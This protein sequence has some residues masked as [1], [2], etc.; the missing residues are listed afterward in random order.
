MEPLGLDDLP[1][2]GVGRGP[3]PTG[4]PVSASLPSSR[5]RADDGD[6]LD[7]GLVRDWAMFVLRAPGRH[8]ALA[9]ACFLAI[10]GGAATSLVVLPKR[11]QVRA[12]ILTQPNPLFI[13][14]A[15][16]GGL[17]QAAREI[18]LRRDNVVA[19]LKQTKF[20]ERHEAT[21]A[22]AAR[23]KAWL[24]D[25]IRGP[26]TREQRLEEAADAVEE[27]LAIGVGATGTLDLS[28]EWSNAELTFDVVQ[29]AIQS[30]IESRYA[31]E[32]SSI[33]E[34]IAILEE[35]ATRL[36]HDIGVRT[37]EVQSLEHELRPTR[38][39]AYVRRPTRRILHD[40][41]LPK[42]E[43]RLAE[44]R[45]AL[46]E[47]ED[48]RRRQVSDLQAQLVQQQTIYADRHPVL[49]AT[50]RNIAALSVQSPAVDSLRSEVA[51]LE[52]DVIG[53]GAHPAEAVREQPFA[54]TIPDL[55]SSPITEDP[56]LEYERYKL[57]LMVRQEN[58]L[59]ERIDTARLTMDTANAGFKYRYSVVSPPQVPK[60]PVSP[61]QNRV[62]AGGLI[63]GLLFALFACVAVDLWGGRVVERWQLE[64]QLGVEVIGEVRERG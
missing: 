6:L 3:S 26:R 41:D 59:L 37:K 48:Y 9:I 5:P 42:L 21:R 49:E 19:L 34:T 55:G 36:N 28:F 14:I 39:P 2:P 35:H 12:T 45:R 10:V 27:R 51:E 63:G 50:R 30:F 8:K 40:E 43:A 4:H 60:G 20:V 24:F 54:S 47:V 57:G 16:S 44:K 58:A 18:I 52:R 32:V 7:L 17:T 22:P 1:R 33:A 25:R 61:R 64:R 31:A 11:Y 13:D 46:A 23:F 56:R 15:Q 53:R 62:L 29:A 38:R